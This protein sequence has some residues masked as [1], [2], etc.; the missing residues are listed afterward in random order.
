MKLSKLVPVVILDKRTSLPFA[1]DDHG[2]L[3]GWKSRHAK[4]G[5]RLRRLDVDLTELTEPSWRIEPYYVSAKEVRRYLKPNPGWPYKPRR[6]RA[7]L[8]Q[9][10]RGFQSVNVRAGVVTPEILDRLVYGASDAPGLI[11][12]ESRRIAV[13]LAIDREMWEWLSKYL[14]GWLPEHLERRFNVSWPGSQTYAFAVAKARFMRYA[15]DDRQ[16]LVR[17]VHSALLEILPESQCAIPLPTVVDANDLIM[18]EVIIPPE[19]RAIDY[20][21]SPQSNL[22]SVQHHAPIQPRTYD[23]LDSAAQ[24]LLRDLTRGLDPEFVADCELLLSGVGFREQ[25]R[26]RGLPEASHATLWRR[27]WANELTAMILSLEPKKIFSPRFEQLVDSLRAK[28]VSNLNY[29]TLL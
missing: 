15:L 14:A 19:L 21:E 7:A 11:Q 1:I 20:L 26:Q 9:F 22:S 24:E 12:K 29:D 27:K 6:A 3:V 5:V 16:H 10:V 17:A 2:E 13:R 8:R 4:Q 25:A 18:P 28:V 23:R